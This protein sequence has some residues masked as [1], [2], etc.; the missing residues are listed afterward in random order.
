MI[1]LGEFIL[2][3]R[4]LKI[5]GVEIQ[6]AY[7]RSRTNRKKFTFVINHIDFVDYLNSGKMGSDSIKKSCGFINITF[8]NSKNE[9]EIVI[10]QIDR[11][12]HDSNINP[13]LQMAHYNIK[14]LFYLLS[15]DEAIFYELIECIIADFERYE[16]EQHFDEYD[17]P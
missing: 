15:T 6:I 11:A 14:Y 4:Y 8:L 7:H 12:N 17:I 10:S 1:E 16:H 5:N 3:C 2:G 13:N 9:S